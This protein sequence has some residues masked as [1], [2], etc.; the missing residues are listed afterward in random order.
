[1]VTIWLKILNLQRNNILVIRK[2]LGHTILKHLNDVAKWCDAKTIDVT[3]EKNFANQMNTFCRDTQK[4]YQISRSEESL[5]WLVK[6][7]L[8]LTRFN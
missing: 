4:H 6:S 3:M 1:M 2:I 7:R 8:V 5:W